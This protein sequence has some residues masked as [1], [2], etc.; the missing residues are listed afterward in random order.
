MAEAL[1]G[2]GLDE[3]AR[4]TGR[5]S[6][7]KARVEVITRGERRRTWTPEQKREIV[8][9]SLD[10]RQSATEVARKHGIST[11]Q[12]YTWRRQLLSGSTA[13]ITR[14]EPR[15]AQVE[16]SPVLSAV[17]PEAPVVEPARTMPVPQPC[18]PDGLIEIVL[19]GG[20]LVRVDAEVDGRALRRVLSALQER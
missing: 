9:E 12:L 20:T 6:A 7:R 10:A 19:P 11:G 15:F 3:S 16:V 14:V 8:A 1:N 13:V 17:A 5:M 4:T 2:S 18:R